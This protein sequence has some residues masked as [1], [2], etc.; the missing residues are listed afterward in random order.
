MNREFD[1][2]MVFRTSGA[3]EVVRDTFS[4]VYLALKEKG[5]DP[6]NQIVGYLI[7]GDPTYITSH[8]NAR[9]LIAKLERDEILE[10]IIRFYLQANRLK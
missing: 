8:R 3:D 5:Y 7:S 6:V 1:E 9:G 2:T 4:Q 10:Y